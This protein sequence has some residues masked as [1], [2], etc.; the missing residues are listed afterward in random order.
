MNRIDASIY[1][2]F[3]P[4]PPDT[5]GWRGDSPVFGKLIDTT[6]PSRI[7]EVG[8]WKGQSAITMGTH[9]KQSGLRCLITCVDTWLGSL[10]FWD[11][12]EDTPERDL[13]LRHGYP[14]VYYQFLSNVVHAGL[15]DVILPFPAPSLIA[16]RYFA[17]QGLTADLVYIDGSHDEQDVLADLRAYFGLVRPGGVLFGDD[18]NWEGVRN[19]VTAF[20][21]ESRCRLYLF[22]EVFWVFQVPP[23]LVLA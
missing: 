23:P 6:R 8:T 18:F 11:G 22:D 14:Q 16:A 7:I 17:R 13:R 3:T 15:Q 21:A 10:E 1:E 20:A 5:R 19:A 12:L 4:L 9:V 2:G